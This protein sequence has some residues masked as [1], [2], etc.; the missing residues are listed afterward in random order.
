METNHVIALVDKLTSIV[1][2]KD[3]TSLDV[4][5]IKINNHRA[6]ASEIKIDPASPMPTDD[7]LLLNPYHG[8]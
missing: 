8:L 7:E 6:K 2:D 5:D 1:K 4:G 3:L